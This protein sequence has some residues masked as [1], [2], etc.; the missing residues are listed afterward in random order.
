MLKIVITTLL[1]LCSA[2]RLGWDDVPTA[3]VT[4]VDEAGY[5][6]WETEV[7][8]AVDAWNTALAER[9]CAAPFVVGAGGHRVTLIA[10]D[11][12]SYD[13]STVG[14][15]IGDSFMSD[16]AIDI[17]NRVTDDPTADHIGNL[18]HELGHALGLGHSD[19]ALGSSIMG[20]P[21]NGDHI[22]P[23]DLDAA[24]CVLG[25]GSCDLEDHFEID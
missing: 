18:T 4:P 15:T 21:I 19:N 2:C 5:G 11:A 16:G 6:D 8:A 14:T 7:S 23:R 9:G 13:P 17:W 24:A 1:L 12:W 25:C 3:T 20:V 22:F 10:R